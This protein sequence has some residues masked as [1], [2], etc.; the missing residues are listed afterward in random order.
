M[1]IERHVKNGRRLA[2][3]LML[4]TVEIGTETEGIDPETGQPIIVIDP[5]YTGRAKIRQQTVNGADKDAGGQGYTIQSFVLSLPFDG[6]AEVTTGM[7]L[8][9]AVN[10]LDTSLEGAMF[11]ISSAS[12]QTVAT[13]RRFEI[14]RTS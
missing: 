1:T 4:T 8:K 3:K 10:P 13:A 6:T 2:E 11:L 9:V 12:G 14:E 5:V 7:A